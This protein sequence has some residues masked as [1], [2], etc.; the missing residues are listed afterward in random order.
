MEEYNLM[1]PEHSTFFLVWELLW[2]LSQKSCPFA[3]SSLLGCNELL[4]FK[5]LSFSSHQ[6]PLESKSKSDP[7]RS[8]LYT[9]ESKIQIQC[10]KKTQCKCKL[11]WQIVFLQ[12]QLNKQQQQDKHIFLFFRF[13][14]NKDKMVF[15]GDATA[16]VNLPYIGSTLMSMVFRS[17]CQATLPTKFYSYLS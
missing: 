4:R 3:F 15:K 7:P 12:K 9:P 13:F 2:F 11:S 17:V 5:A 1:S 10:L 16:Y 6:C 8:H 14:L